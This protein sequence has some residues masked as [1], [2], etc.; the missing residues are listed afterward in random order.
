MS[1]SW[2]RD[3]KCPRGQRMVWLMQWGLLSDRQAFDSSHDRSLNSQ[4]LLPLSLSLFRFS[5]GPIRLIPRIQSNKYG[6]KQRARGTVR[7]FANRLSTPSSI[8]MWDK[9][10]ACLDIS[11]RR[12]G[13]NSNHLSAC[14]H[15]THGGREGRVKG[16]SVV[17]EGT[18]CLLWV[19]R[20][21]RKRLRCP[22]K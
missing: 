3:L 6:N 18:R 17:A 5:Q 9:F 13:S 15:A 12:Q 16:I 7:Q 14:N 2:G 1:A 8:K 20:D 4:T 11:V 10:K 22:R 21:T 19:L